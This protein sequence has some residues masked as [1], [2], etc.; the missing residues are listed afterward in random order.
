[1]ELEFGNVGFLWREENRRTGRRTNNK[2]HPRITPGLG[3]EN[4]GHIGGRRVLSPLHHAGSPYSF[5]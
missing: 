4:K 5:S 2:L 1:V 3:I